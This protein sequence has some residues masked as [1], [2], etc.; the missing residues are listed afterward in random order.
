[1]AKNWG[2]KVIGTA[3]RPNSVAL[4]RKCGIDVVLDHKQDLISQLNANGYAKGVDYILVNF[5]PFSYWRTLMEAIKPQGKI[6][7]L[8]ESSE[9][10]DLKLLKDKSVT[11]VSEMMATRINV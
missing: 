9:L 10:L 6:C 4:S 2:L 7:L 8:V 5:D 11:L 1:M 3:S